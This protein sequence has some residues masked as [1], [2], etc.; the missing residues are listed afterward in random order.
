MLTIG[1]IS[2]V[3]ASSST[4][5]YAKNKQ[6]RTRRRTP[7]TVTGP[8]LHKWPA[9]K[10]AREYKVK[11]ELRL[12]NNK[13]K[14]IK[15]RSVIK[16]I[17]TPKNRIREILP[18]GVY[19]LTVYPIYKGGRRGK[20]LRPV[21]KRTAFPSIEPLSPRKA[22]TIP[23]NDKEAKV[24]FKWKE[25]KYVHSYLL[26]VKQVST[27]EI[28]EQTTLKT[29]HTLSLKRDLDYEWQ[30]RPDTNIRTSKVF[31]WTPFAIGSSDGSRKLPMPV[32]FQK[33]TDQATWERTPGAQ[34]YLVTLYNK[35]DPKDDTNKE[36]EWKE[37]WKNTQV[38]T[39]V[40]LKNK[41]TKG[42]S[43][44]LHVK[45]QA[46]GSKDSKPAVFEFVAGKNPIFQEKIAPMRRISVDKDPL[47]PTEIT[48]DLVGV[49]GGETLK[50]RGIIGEFEGQ[51]VTTGGFMDLEILPKPT[52]NMIYVKIKVGGEAFESVSETSTVSSET[53]ESVDIKSTRTFG[54]LSVSGRSN[55]SKDFYGFGIEIASLAF[56][57]FVAE[58]ED[59]GEGKV[60]AEDI[61]T[62]GMTLHNRFQILGGQMQNHM[63]LIP[64]SNR[65]RTIAAF[66]WTV[67]Q[68]YW[69]GSAFALSI[70]GHLRYA[71]ATI[72][73]ECSSNI[74]GVCAYPR[75]DQITGGGLV[76]MA[77][78]W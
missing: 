18:Y 43:Y 46:K 77:V 60:V 35:E 25:S 22:E 67:K 40:Y 17:R 50:A 45:A 65:T 11:F 64:L 51:G 28:Q 12:K 49:Y 15:Y 30:V 39:S 38:E 66:D 26:R 59:T 20:R 36:K 58:N 44:R 52:A 14:K 78:R 68:R 57:K 47:P 19:R 13:K 48:V 74:E 4:W 71:K 21:L 53:T 2:L 70:G 16:G 69:I 23:V 37:T 32:F 76:G 41:T 5:G 42:L 61:I 29:K 75:S 56:P 63:T 1:L 3:L 8:I 10:G 34:E 24:T 62:I 27:G 31:I 73:R 7:V 33:S 6:P 55:L 9:V 72:Q 54:S